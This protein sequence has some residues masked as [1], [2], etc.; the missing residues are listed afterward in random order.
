[1]IKLGYGYNKLDK[2]HE[3]S[4]VITNHADNEICDCWTQWLWFGVGETLGGM[5]VN[6]RP[7]LFDSKIIKTWEGNKYNGVEYGRLVAKNIIKK[8]EQLGG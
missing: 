5:K 2:Q 8:L 3:F 4:L 1:M 6:L 7:Y